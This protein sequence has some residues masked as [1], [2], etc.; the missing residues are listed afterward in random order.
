VTTDHRDPV[1]FYRSHAEE[2]ARVRSGPSAEGTWLKSFMAELLPSGSILD[3]GCGTGEPIARTLVEHGFLVT[4]LDTTPAFLDLAREKVPDGVFL[5]GDLRDF[6]LGR[7]FDGVL[8]WHSLFHLGQDDQ[9]AAI[10]R[11]AAH[12]APTAVL[13]F[14]AGDREGEAINPMFGENLYHASLDPGE[15]R[16]IL[17]ALGFRILRYVERDPGAGFSTVWLARRDDTG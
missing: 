12:A 11:L 3:A 9:R 7:T 13:M 17:Q 1:D 8:A 10:V 14:T 15:Y 5:E 4:G 6:S 16:T 2:F